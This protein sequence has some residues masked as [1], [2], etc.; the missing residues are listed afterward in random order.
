MVDIAFIFP[1]QGSQYVGM[2]KD[3]YD[4]YPKAREIF[5]K[6]NEVLNISLTKY[7]FDGPAEE[8]KQTLI[9]QPAILTL[10]IAL[11]EVLKEKNSLAPRFTAG[12][13]LGEYSALA[14]AGVLSFENAL[15]LVQKR[16][17]FMEDEAQKVKGKMA[18]VLGVD[19]DAVD[20]IC[21]ETNSQIANFNSR[22]QIVITGKADAIDKAVEILQQQ[23]KKVVVL[24]VSG[25]FHSSLMSK[26]AE[27]FKDVLAN[28]EFKEAKTEI[29]ANVSARP[30]RLPDEIRDNLFRQITSSV[31]WC[32]SILH[33]KAQGVKR[34]FE[35]GPGKVLRG[36]MRKTDDSLEVINIEKIE[37]IVNLNVV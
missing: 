9:C 15:R 20:K 23:G 7:C 26:A 5:E 29:I 17:S 8:L 34:F 22:E 1:G 24:E 3:L 19:K 32:D 18:A 37:D 36:L 2:G 25:A 31:L 14:A 10:S 11:L 33:M 30:V 4:N 6:A 27:R 35:I 28:I 13:S 12:L 16:A 21:K